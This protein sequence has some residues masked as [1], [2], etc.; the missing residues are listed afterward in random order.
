[1]S[2]RLTPVAIAHLL[3]A[4]K[5]TCMFINSQVAR[6]AKETLTILQ[7]DPEVNTIPLFADALSYEE[8]LDPEN[9]AHKGLPVPPV[10]T[11][12]KYE[13]RDAVILHSSG[14]TGLPKPIFHAQAYLLIYGAC[15]RLPE[16]KQAFR[17]NVSTLP[18]YH[19]RMRVPL[20]F[21]V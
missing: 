14:T 5:P 19:V 10:Y 12:F 1:M 8:L 17:F 13:D 20:N 16:Q 6:A 18:L 9:S 7:D 21:R 15:H 4:T 11:E 3:K 2:A